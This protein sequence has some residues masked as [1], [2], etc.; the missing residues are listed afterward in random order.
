MRMV[1]VGMFKDYL[2][3][4]GKEEGEVGIFPGFLSEG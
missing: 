2:G 3:F 4:L 1:E